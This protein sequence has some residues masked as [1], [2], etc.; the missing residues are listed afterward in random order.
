MT[1]GGRSES[2]DGDNVMTYIISSDCMNCAVCEFMCPTNAISQ[3]PNQLII[4]KRLCDGCGKCVPYCVVG[5][6]VPR[7]RFSER[8]G[9]TVRARMREVLERR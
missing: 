4:D 8:Q 9:R 5:A 2:I 1:S 7:D 6:I 3:A